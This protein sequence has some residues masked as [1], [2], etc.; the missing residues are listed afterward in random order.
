MHSAEYPVNVPTS[1][2]R[3][4]PGDAGE[5]ADQR[6]FISADLHDRALTGELLRL[7][8]EVQLDVVGLRGPGGD[9]AAD[10]GV[11][12]RLVRS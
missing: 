7:A 4:A 9:V 5:K 11:Q 3:R 1:T 2:A 12:P 10:S 8:D 6:T